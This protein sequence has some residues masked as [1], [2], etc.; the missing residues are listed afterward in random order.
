MVYTH[1]DLLEMEF[2]ILKKIEFS[3]QETS[4][5][6]FL[7]RYAI[8]AQASTKIQMMSEYLLDLSL[9]DSKMN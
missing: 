8:V 1:G 5:L 3:V 4:S 6:T 2:N 7:Q 9:L